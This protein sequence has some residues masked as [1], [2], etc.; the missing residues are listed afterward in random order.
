MAGLSQTGGNPVPG[1][2]VRRV[3]RGRPGG[4][5][6]AYGS[7]SSSVSS[8]NASSVVSSGGRTRSRFSISSSSMSSSRSSSSSSSSRSSV[9]LVYGP[10]VRGLGGGREADLAVVARVLEDLA[11]DQADV[12]VAQRGH[13]GEVLVAV[14]HELEQAGGHARLHDADPDAVAERDQPVALRHQLHGVARVDLGQLCRPGEVGEVGEARL[15]GLLDED[16]DRRL[17]ARLRRHGLLAGLDEQ[18]LEALDVALGD[19]VGGVELERPHVV[20]ARRAQLALLPE[21]LGQ[22]VLRLRV[23]AELDEAPVGL[24]GIGPAGRRRVRD[25]LLGELALQAR[26]AG[27]RLGGGVDLGEGH[28]CGRP[29]GS[30]GPRHRATCRRRTCQSRD[31]RGHAFLTPTEPGVKRAGPRR[32]VCAALRP[33]AGGS[34]PRPRSPG[35]PAGAS[36]TGTDAP[37]GGPAPIRA[38]R[39]TGRTP[40]S[41]R[42]ARRAAAGRS[43]G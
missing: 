11:D 19:A 39:P 38:G 1:G 22:A 25:G 29:F 16:A 18:H 40:A 23:G 4:G 10:Q 24:G 12:L 30:I 5:R 3:G 37:A 17:A 26:L 20:L 41:A 36:P 14:G 15:A 6:S 28:G 33:G 43:R 2:A 32:R 8:T 13:A 35:R 27:R 42:R 21:R 7:S 34:R 31:G 9:P